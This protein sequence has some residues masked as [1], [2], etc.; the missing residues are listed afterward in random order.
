MFDAAGAKVGTE[1]GVNPVQAAYYQ[2]SPT[3]SGLT[4]GGFV[5]SYMEIAWNNNSVDYPIN[6]NVYAQLFDATGSEVGTRTLVHTDAREDI[7]Q[8]MSAT[9]TGLADGGFVVAWK[10]KSGDSGISYGIAAQIFDAAGVKVG[11]EFLVDTQGGSIQLVP[12]ITGLANG[13]FVV[14]WFD[15]TV[16]GN[17]NYSIDINAQIFDA[18]GAKVGTELLVNTVTDGGQYWPAV[19]GLANGS[20]VI[21]WADGGSGFYD[22]NRSGLEIKAQVFSATGV[23]SGPEFQVNTAVLRDQTYPKVAALSDGNFVITWQDESSGLGD[24][25]AQI[26]SPI[27]GPVAANGAGNGNEDAAING[28]LA[29]S[30]ANG[31]ALTY[32][33]V[34]NAQHGN[35][36]VNADGSYIYTPNANY[37]G[38]DSF[39][40]KANDGAFDSNVATVTLTVAAVNDT[41][42]AAN[43]AKT[44]NED[45]SIAGTLVA[46]DVDGTPLTYS[47]VTQAAH[48]TVAVNANGTYAYTPVANYS[49]PD[50]FTFKASDGTL[51][52]N[53]ATVTLTVTAVND[54]PVAANGAGSGARTR[55]SPA[56]SRRAISKAPRS[57]TA[58]SRRRRTAA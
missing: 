52:S 50:S 13:S 44:G 45:T 29:A 6:Y 51:D 42:V 19:T 34:A 8:G 31:D 3:V 7:F 47:V 25:K 35:V 12:S 9:I 41:P 22:P 2:Y 1:F 26:F 16:L 49:G 24:I 58:G 18:A 53:V 38:P 54:A 5:V 48:G 15:T 23:K 55:P 32:A 33:R 30:D 46:S 27:D 56:R 28:T 36:V 10:Y 40:F 57:L 20:F 17:G 11:S 21:T 39:T 37:N 4:N 14:T 43:G